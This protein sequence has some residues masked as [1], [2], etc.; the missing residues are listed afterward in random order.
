MLKLDNPHHD[1]SVIVLRLNKFIFYIHSGHHHPVH[2]L[3]PLSSS[4][5][6]LYELLKNCRQYHGNQIKYTEIVTKRKG[7]ASIVAYPGN[8]NT[9]VTEAEGSQV[10]AYPQLH[11]VFEDS[12]G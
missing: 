8:P 6:I 1:F 11:N 7:I 5:S 4:S 9:Q 10:Q 2:I 12:L 3:Y